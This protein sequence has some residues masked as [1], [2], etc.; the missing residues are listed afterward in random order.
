MAIDDEGAPADCAVH[1]RQM[2]DANYQLAQ[3][4][5]APD[6]IANY[7]DLAFEY[8]RCADLSDKLTERPDCNVVPFPSVRAGRR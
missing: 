6:I 5:A 1:C 7:L 2:A 3:Q 4:D 8:T